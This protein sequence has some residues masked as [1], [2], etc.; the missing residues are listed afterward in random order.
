[1]PDDTTDAAKQVAA[2]LQDKGHHEHAARLG[3]ALAEAKAD[4]L[5]AVREACQT[6]LTALEAIDPVSANLVDELR[7]EVDKRLGPADPAPHGT[8]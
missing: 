5:L 1:M 4:T 2:R 7:M 6:I 3:A 8:H